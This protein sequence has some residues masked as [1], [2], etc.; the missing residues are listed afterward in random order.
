LA[1]TGPTRLCARCYGARVMPK[2]IGL[3]EIN[4]ALAEGMAKVLSRELDFSR[5]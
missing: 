2:V 4:R 3:R 1:Y 5:V